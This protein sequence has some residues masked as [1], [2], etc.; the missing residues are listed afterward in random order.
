MAVLALSELAPA[1]AQF[2]VGPAYPAYPFGYAGS[3]ST[4][5]SGFGF[6]VVGPRF[7]VNAFSGGFVRRSAF[8]GAPVFGFPVAPVGFFNPFAP[9]VVGFGGPFIGGWGPAFG[10]PVVAVPV[11]VPVPVAVGPP[12]DDPNPAANAQLLPRGARDGDFFVIAPKKGLAFPAEKVAVPKMPAPAAV[13]GPF[14][15][16][17]P[18]KAEVADPDPK[19]EL[20]RLL[21]LAQESF[22]TGD[23]GRAAEHAERAIAV[24]PAG[25]WAYFLLGQAKFA[26]GQY[27][28]AAAHIREGLVRDPKWPA[29]A[30][31]PPD[32]YGDRPERFVL[33]LLAL[34]KAMADVPDQ[35]TL[36]FLL[37]Y[38]LWFSGEKAEAD[39][40]FRAAEKRLPDPGPI[41]LF[42][43]P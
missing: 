9:V 37:G 16:V 41:A 5:R 39:K 2:V 21:K 40:L 24:D 8:F 15:P 17:V 23:Y 1:R 42:K 43:L 20:A 11:P 3:Y 19:K 27:V 32:L 30:F 29:A 14:K 35:A 12:P 22:A 18:V 31:N 36:E 34:K 28:D 4:F 38:E 33:H 25:A 10:P 6:S 13:P 26:S 7:R